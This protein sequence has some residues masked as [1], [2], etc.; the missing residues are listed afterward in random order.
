MPHRVFCISTY[1]LCLLNI[2]QHASE[3]QVSAASDDNLGWKA[4]DYP[5]PVLDPNACGLSKDINGKHTSGHTTTTFVQRNN[6]FTED[7][8]FSWV[9]D[10][11]N[12]LL[13]HECKL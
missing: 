11:D 2:L 8:I 7:N 9:C 13:E 5:D 1:L 6:T 10:P 12:V 3:L 4:G